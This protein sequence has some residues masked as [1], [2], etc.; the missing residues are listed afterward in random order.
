[1]RRAA[2]VGRGTFTFIGDA[3]EVGERIAALTRRLEGPVLTD[4]TVDWD[5][6]RAE[7]WPSPLGDLYAGEPLL[8]TARLLRRGDGVRVEGSRDGSFWQAAVDLDAAAAAPASAGGVG[9][10]I[11]QLWAARKI[12]SLLGR[13]AEGVPEAEVRPE[14]VRV[15]LEHH[16]VSRYTS[17]VAVDV[18]PARSAGEPLRSAAVAT[19]LPAGVLPAGGTASQLDLLL[20]VALLLAAA[21]GAALGRRPPVRSARR[22]AAP[23]G[24]RR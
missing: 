4:L 1:M 7:V 11:H 14:V 20:G 24:G 2:E 15:A 17:L 22:P 9:R 6:P 8:V 12:E 18:T 5:D 10:G 21:A 3:A 16:L 19:A 23:L 13:L